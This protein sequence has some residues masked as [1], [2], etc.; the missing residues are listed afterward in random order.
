MDGTRGGFSS[1]LLPVVDERVEPISYLFYNKFICDLRNIDLT[2][3][4]PQRHQVSTWD[5]LS[6]TLRVHYRNIAPSLAWGNMLK[7]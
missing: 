4:K 5:A 6:S 2:K 3:Q 7:R 1:E